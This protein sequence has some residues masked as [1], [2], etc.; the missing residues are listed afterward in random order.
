MKGIYLFD[1]WRLTTLH[2]FLLADAVKDEAS[3]HVVQQTEAIVRSLQGH[4]IYLSY[5]TQTTHP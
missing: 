1:T 5:N 3:L 2:S 4:H